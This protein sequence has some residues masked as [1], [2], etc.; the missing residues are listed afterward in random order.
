M[1]DRTE[2]DIFDDLAQA[3]RRLAVGRILPDGD[4][5]WPLTEQVCD[6]LRR[7]QTVS[8]MSIKEVSHHMGEGFSRGTLCR[9]LASSP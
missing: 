1:P 6:D 9:W 5:P 7:Y 8:G 4:L 3:P 2:R